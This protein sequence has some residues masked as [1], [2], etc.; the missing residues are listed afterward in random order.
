VKTPG[1]GWPLLLASGVLAACAL[2]GFFASPNSRAPRSV[3]GPS[4]DVQAVSQGAIA[5][6]ASKN[7]EEIRIGDRVLTRDPE[8]RELGYRRVVRVFQRSSDHLRVVEVQDARAGVQH[9]E[10]TDE[11]PFWVVGVGFVEAGKLNAGDQLESPD[12]GRQTVLN[13]RREEQPLGMPVFNFE[14]EDWHTYYVRAHGAQAPPILV[15]NADCGGGS[16]KSLKD[17]TAGERRTHF[18]N[19]GVPTTQLGPSG[20]PKVHT[21]EKSTLKEAQDAARQAGGSKPIKHT[22]DRGQPTH[23]HPVD[24]QG[25]KLTGKDNVHFQQRGAT[26]NP[27]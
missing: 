6:W 19:K 27:E 5:P 7:I 12:G 8:T 18:E 2:L 20:Y 16:T 11:H 14:V 21:V 10:T 25:N 24:Q 13:T 9:F 3:A 4:L 22:Q 17:M 1:R 26:P 23:F 15:H